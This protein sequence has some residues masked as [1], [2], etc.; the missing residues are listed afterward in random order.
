MFLIP[1]VIA[2]VGTSSIELK[3]RLLS[4]L[5]PSAKVTTNVSCS[6][7]VPGSLEP[8]WPLVPIPSNCKSIEVLEGDKISLKELSV[9]N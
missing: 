6:N 4:C 1:I 5:V 9:V 2:W 8:M 7:D 3:K